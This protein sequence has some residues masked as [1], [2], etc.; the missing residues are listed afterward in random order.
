ML[1]AD[2]STL[3]LVDEAKQELWSRVAKGKDLS[4]IRIP[5]SAG[6]AGHVARTG[7]TVNIADAYRDPRFNIDVDHRTGYHTRT[8]LCKIGRA[9]V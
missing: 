7:E 8:I 1:E 9:H 5:L 4:E 3:F 6:I 2:R